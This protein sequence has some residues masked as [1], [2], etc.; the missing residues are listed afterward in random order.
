MQ[1][2]SVCAPGESQASPPELHGSRATSGEREREGGDS[3]KQEA[4]VRGRDR[5]RRRGAGKNVESQTW[6]SGFV[7]MLCWISGVSNP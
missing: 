7:A 4:V 1:C 5:G 2:W 3:G 6:A